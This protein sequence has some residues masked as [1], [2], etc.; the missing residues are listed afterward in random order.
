MFARRAQCTH[1]SLLIARRKQQP[2]L[3]MH[4]VV[5]NPADCRRYDGNACYD[6]FLHS[7]R[8]GIRTSWHQQDRRGFQFFRDLGR[9]QVMFEF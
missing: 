9:Q 1:E 2:I 5:G 3:P 6:G 8:A 7:V 4:Y